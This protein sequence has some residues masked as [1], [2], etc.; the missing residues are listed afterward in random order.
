[1][2]ERARCIP[3]FLPAD[4]YHQQQQ[5]PTCVRG[6]AI[7][8]Q[9]YQVPKQPAG[10]GAWAQRERTPAGVV[11]N[12][13][14]S[15]V[16]KLVADP[17]P[18]G[19]GNKMAGLG[20]ASNDI[21]A[22]DQVRKQ[23]LPGAPAPKSDRAS[24][25]GS[26]GLAAGLELGG[27]DVQEVISTHRA[28]GCSPRGSIAAELA[29]YSWLEDKEHGPFHEAVCFESPNQQRT[30]SHHDAAEE[31]AGVDWGCF[32]NSPGCQMRSPPYEEKELWCMIESISP[33]FEVPRPA[34]YIPPVSSPGAYCNSASTYSPGRILDFGGGCFD[35]GG[36][37]YSPM[38]QS[39]A[40]SP[41][42]SPNHGFRQ[43]NA[44]GSPHEAPF[45][46]NQR[47]YSPIQSKHGHNHHIAHP[48]HQPLPLH[49]IAVRQAFIRHQH[50]NQPPREAA[51]QA[52][53]NLQQ[54][55]HVSPDD[56]H[57]DWE[58]PTAAARACSLPIQSPLLC[59]SQGGRGTAGGSVTAHGGMTDEKT[60]RSPPPL[61]KQLGGHVHYYLNM[62]C[63]PGSQQ[64]SA[65]GLSNLS[66][67]YSR[68]RVRTKRAE[69]PSAL[70]LADRGA[71]RPSHGCSRLQ[72]MACASDYVAHPA[73]PSKS[74][75]AGEETS[76][77]EIAQVHLSSM[78]SRNTVSNAVQSP[79]TC[80]RRSPSHTPANDPLATVRVASVTPEP[81]AKESSIVS[82]HALAFSGTISQ[83]R[84]VAESIAGVAAANGPREGDSPA[85]LTPI[86]PPA[87][88]K[89]Y[90]QEEHGET[91]HSLRRGDLQATAH[92]SAVP[93]AAQRARIKTPSA[94][95][96][97]HHHQPPPPPKQRQQE[98]VS[99]HTPAWA[100]GC[101]EQGAG[102][103]I[104]ARVSGAGGDEEECPRL[105]W[106][107]PSQ[108]PS[109]LATQ[110]PSLWFP[111]IKAPTK[112]TS[113]KQIPLAQVVHPLLRS[114]SA[115]E[116]W[117]GSGGVVSKPTVKPGAAL[118]RTLFSEQA[119]LVLHEPPS[120]GSPTS[121]TNST[122][123]FDASGAPFALNRKWAVQPCTS[124][125]LPG[126][127]AVIGASGAP[128]ALD[129][130]WAFQPSKSNL[131]SELFPRSQ[132]ASPAKEAVA[133][134][135]DVTSH[136]HH[137]NKFKLATDCLPDKN[138]PAVSQLP[139]V[140]KPSVDR[141]RW[142]RPV[143]AGPLLGMPIVPEL[144]KLV[145]RRVASAGPL[146]PYP[147]PFPRPPSPR[148]PPAYVIPTRPQQAGQASSSTQVRAGMAVN[149]KDSRVPMLAPLKA[150][151]P[152][153]RGRL[154]PHKSG[155]SILHSQNAYSRNAELT[156]YCTHKI[157][158]SQNPLAMAVGPGVGVVVDYM[159]ARVW[160]PAPAAV[161]PVRPASS[162][163]RMSGLPR[164]T[165]NSSAAADR[166]ASGRGAD[167]V[168]GG[169]NR[170]PSGASYPTRPSSIYTAPKRNV[171]GDTND[172]MPRPL[173][174]RKEVEDSV[175]WLARKKKPQTQPTDDDHRSSVNVR[176]QPWLKDEAVGQQQPAWN[177]AEEGRGHRALPLQPHSGDLRQQRDQN[178]Q[179]TWMKA[180]AFA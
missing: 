145:S 154:R 163:A 9:G 177:K 89:V 23:P 21:K 85:V 82:K 172:C 134:G 48:P 1:M 107:S 129:Q 132:T 164:P 51:D 57:A 112:V 32:F 130:K 58:Q 162:R 15:R 148:P 125:L 77:S 133:N 166:P 14:A 143:S 81:A 153:V 138:P 65:P 66:P 30:L 116:C 87:H 100:L 173:S 64:D 152:P 54:Q 78:Y 68:L 93:G 67:G 105:R 115:P 34:N 126:L 50:R 73:A 31:E 167:S 104:P 63:S 101:E 6:S 149:S 108:S 128:R 147:P 102:P 118:K 92:L 94:P 146:V 95:H 97:Y 88:A 49:H 42:F 98:A 52:P 74:C 53:L 157:L 170:P 2:R 3:K 84:G 140:I 38:Q 69:P 83:K 28:S 61:N 165:R 11:P 27:G 160:A 96:Q 109:S 13:V 151:Q 56:P 20:G 123:V 16:K 72:A 25:Y 135:L 91:T 36:G 178:K 114:P 29:G 150:G 10:E 117:R 12:S 71:R 33:R 103:A 46:P 55:L 17:Q 158:H 174:Y 75:A 119:A 106:V 121:P 26:P 131:L 156:E 22:K 175:S 47:I 124:N 168:R 44:H 110:G 141:Q 24:K 19:G 8:A 120:S 79:A 144:P 155:L 113:A 122:A 137:Q 99:S 35:G 171:T 142:G 40:D 43:H 159:K 62:A 111:P 161:P 90:I 60:F 169:E 180:R 136:Q 86:Y 176:Q 39:P 5:L 80:G 45:S 127:S 139:R 18:A 37:F 7:L 76:S 4:S 41:V 179:E 59:P 70:E